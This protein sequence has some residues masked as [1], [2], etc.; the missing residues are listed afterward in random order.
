MSSIINLL[1]KELVVALGT[2]ASAVAFRLPPT[3]LELLVEGVSLTVI[4][5]A[6]TATTQPSTL[7]PPI[8]ILNVII[9]QVIT[10]VAT[11][12]LLN[13]TIKKKGG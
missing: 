6:A 4:N 3:K 8:N 12:A 9:K 7:K 1:N 10:L 13:N 5:L 11:L 2:P